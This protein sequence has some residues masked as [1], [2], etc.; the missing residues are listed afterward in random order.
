MNWANLLRRWTMKSIHATI[1]GSA[2]LG[3]ASLAIAQ[4]TPSA[5]ASK[6]PPI[7]YT[8][9]HTFNLPV[10]MDRNDRLQLTE[11]RLY[12]RTPSSPWT[13]QDKGGPDLTQFNCKVAQ[14]GEYWYTLAL[15]DKQGRV[16]PDVNMEP[17][18]QRVVIDTTMPTLQVQASDTQGDFCLRC[19]VHDANPDHA[20]LRAVCKTDKG[21]IP[22]ESVPGQPGSFRVRGSEMMRFPIVFSVADLAGN[23]ATK[24]VNVRDLVG[25]T[26]GQGTPT[27]AAK[28]PPLTTPPATL[29]DA[30]PSMKFIAPPAPLKNDVLPPP[31][32]DGVQPRTDS[33][34][35]IEGG[36]FRGVGAVLPPPTHPVV[37]P[38]DPAKDHAGPH[39]LISTTQAAIEYRIDQVGPS[40]VGKVEIYMTP[41]KGQTWHRLAEDIAKR[42]PVNVNLPGDGVYGIRIVVT[43]GNG[44]GG[45]APVRGD[46]PHY[47]LEVDTTAPFV[48]FRSADVMPSTGQVELRWNATDRNLGADPVS[49]FYRTKQDGTWQV[50]ARGIKND[51]IYRWAFPRDA[52]GQFFFKVEVTDRANNASH[53]V[54]TQATV[55]DMTEPQ[56]TVIGVTGGA[57]P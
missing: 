21:D 30:D 4:G 52:G 45:K 6:L 19:T 7:H 24:E 42:S 34:R 23:I 46:A 43:N 15:V 1:L 13:L 35:I 48:Q 51:G 20:T 18:Q 38:A 25:S 9:S 47:T 54:S 32:N 41:D 27:Q 8:R 14:D 31:R 53:A 3:S 49:L 50:I 26:L 33:P 44:F 40:G 2:L 37:T 17:P 36:E 39:H 22:L 57:R 28:A 29:P 5:A 55:I 10:L 56:V 16:T 11:I 12:V